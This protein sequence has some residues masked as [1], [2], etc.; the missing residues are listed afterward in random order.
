[1]W[2]DSAAGAQV[3][4]TQTIP[5]AVTN[6]LFTVE[7]NASGQITSGTIFNGE[8][9]WLALAVRCP[10][11]SGGYTALNPR[12][13]MTPAPMAFALPGFYTQENAT[14]P[15]VIGGYSGNVIS[16]TWVGA[17][18]AGGGNSTLP[19]KAWTNYAAIGGG[20][21]NTASGSVAAIGGGTSNIASGERA[22]V[23][24]GYENTA[25]GPFA[26]VPGGIQ[27]AAS[28]YG[29]M[30]YAS[31]YFAPSGFGEAQTSLYVMRIQTTNAIATEMFLDGT[32]ASQRITIANNRV[33]TFDILVVGTNINNGNSAGYRLAGAIKNIGGTTLFIGTPGQVIFG[34]DN[35][36]WDAI[37]EADN[38]ND[39]LVVK[40]VGVGGQDIRW[41]ASVR[42]VEVAY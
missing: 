31:G 37:V 23:S 20:R 41:V 19:N 29:E 35:P 2:D 11:G 16:P 25:S 4:V 17:M 3:G 28:H 12:Q 8:A 7:L 21:G 14:S 38:T 32:A 5:S 24:G 34:E 27:A 1:L 9:R 13:R 26:T 39:A 6:G 40:V 42:T 18:I 22:T 33:L 30:A 15:N 10:S 36:A